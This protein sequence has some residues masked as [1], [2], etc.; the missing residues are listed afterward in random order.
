MGNCLCERIGN[1]I[2]SEGADAMCEVLSVNTSLTRLNMCC[3]CCCCDEIM[4]EM[5]EKTEKTVN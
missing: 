4:M 5:I 3:C 1:R 2:G